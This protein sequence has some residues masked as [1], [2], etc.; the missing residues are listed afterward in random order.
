MRDRLA[1][2]GVG[3]QSDGVEIARFFQPRIERGDRIG[4]V[5]PKEA[6]PKVAAS[7]PGDHRIKDLPPAIGAV[8]VAV[9]QG[10]ALQHAELVEQEVGVVAGAVEMP[11]PGGPFLI[12][13]GRADRAVHIQH[14]VI[15]TVSV[16]K[17][18]DPLSVQIGQRRP[19]LDRGQC[20]GLE[21]PH[22][23]S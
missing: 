6:A 3:G 14:D 5:R 2:D 7:I 9:T 1:Q 21:P 11:I 18:V 10:T 22:L 4:S 16:M 23:G 19:V 17:P 13:V 15:Q 20:L 8:D 12:A